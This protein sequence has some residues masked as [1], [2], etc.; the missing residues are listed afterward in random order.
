MYGAA[1]CSLVLL[2]TVGSAGVLARLSEDTEGTNTGGLDIS[3]SQMLG[4]TVDTLAVLE[5]EVMYNMRSLTGADA[6]IGLEE[7]G[8]TLV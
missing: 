8:S 3:I 2:M 4:V 6:R 1:A 5:A 7:K